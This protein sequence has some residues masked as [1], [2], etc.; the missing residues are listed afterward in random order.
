MNNVVAQ[1]N[2]ISPEINGYL[3]NEVMGLSPTEIILKIYDF[4]ILNLKKKEQQKAM[5]AITELIVSLNFEYKD[6]SIG[7]YK[8]YQYCRDQIIHGNYDNALVIL[9][10]LR[11]SWAK[12]FNLE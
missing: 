9:E 11:D 6:F 5:R 2:E 3:K 7:M 10:G 4:A 8:L 1:K 12:A